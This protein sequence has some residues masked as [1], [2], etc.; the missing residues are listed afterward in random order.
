MCLGALSIDSVI[1]ALLCHLCFLRTYTCRPKMFAPIV[2]FHQRPYVLHSHLHLHLKVHKQLYRTNA[3]K[4]AGNF[5]SNDI[6]NDAIEKRRKGP[7]NG[8][9]GIHEPSRW[10]QLC[11]LQ[12]PK[13]V[14]SPLA[15]APW[16]EFYE[17][18]CDSLILSRHFLGG[19][20]GGSLRTI[21]IIIIIIIIINF[22]SSNLK[23]FQF[24]M[25]SPCLGFDASGGRTV[26]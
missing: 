8:E 2:Q 4:M 18:C 21:I 5:C 16:C 9:V 24:Q 6:S 12:P 13:S 14:P 25:P 15:F 19:E 22:S 11:C 7:L 23:I 3:R 20:C 26:Y 17:R 1:Y 10:Q